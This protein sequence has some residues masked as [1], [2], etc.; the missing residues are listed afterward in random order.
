MGQ[1]P[2]DQRAVPNARGKSRIVVVGAGIAGLST[3]WRLAASGRADV[4]VLE[5]ESRLQRHSTGRNAGIL[6]TLTGH[7]PLD[8]LG[9][10]SKA[11]FAA[12]PPEIAS[13]PLVD[14]RGLLLGADAGAPAEALTAMVR[15]APVMPEALDPAAL[16]ELAPHVARPAAVLFRYA[17][18]GLIDIDALVSG[19]HR[20]LVR[21]GG[22]LRLGARVV[23]LERTA[24]Q[25]SAVVLAN[26]ERVLAD[27]VVLGP[28]AWAGEL[29]ERAGSPLRFRP[30]RRHAAITVADARLHAGAPPAWIAGDA[31]YSRP[32]EGGLMVCACDQT[33]TAPGDYAKD[34]SELERLA[35]S[36][37]RH[38]APAALRRFERTWVGHRTFCADDLFAIG[39]DPI[40]QGLIWAAGLGGHGI[41]TSPET[42]RLA[43]AAAL[44]DPDAGL[45]PFAPG[46]FLVDQSPES[47][48]SLSKGSV[49]KGSAPS[50]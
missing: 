14:G 29:A 11:F 20:A 36:T 27:R 45:A 1:S 8:A 39:A 26:G 19:L 43:A 16:H 38:L 32:S 13:A 18:E 4:I 35:L 25:L 46:R 6:R 44:G 7:G 17:D 47:V 40:V 49:S 9:P 23:E 50:T 34:S 15:A 28:G 41:S 48:G 3:A 12:P 5:A 42:G 33:A 24:G 2:P 30:T 21:A 31:F 37:E 22:E 10:A